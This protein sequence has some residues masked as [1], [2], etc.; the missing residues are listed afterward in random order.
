[1]VQSDSGILNSSK[2]NV[3]LLFLFVL[4]SLRQRLT[5]FELTAILKPQPPECWDSTLEIGMNKTLC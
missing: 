4:F 1:M 5:G 3:L 2:I